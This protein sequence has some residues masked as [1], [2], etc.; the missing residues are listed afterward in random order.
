MKEIKGNKK[1]EQNEILHVLHVFGKLNRGGAESRVMD[2]YRNVDRAKV[3]FDFM[4]HTTKVCDFQPEIE[5]LGGKVYHV[6]PFRFWNY[7]S[8]CKAWKQ[9]IREHP[10]IR[11]VHGHMTSTASIYLP[12]VHKKGV[13][14]I[15]HSRNA[16]VDKGIKGKLTKF[17]RRNLTEKCDRCF[18]CSKLAG[19]AVFGKEAMEQGNVTIIPNAID[20]ARF[21]FDPE[22]RKQKREEL[23]IQPEEFLIG[24]VG[25]FDPQ[26]N[27]KYAVEILAECRKKNFPAKLIL[28]GE[29]PLMETVRQ[30]VEELQLQEYVIFTGLQKNVVPFYQAMDFFLLPSFYEGLPGVAVEAQASG[31][32]GILSDAITTETAMTSLMEFRNV[33][34]P[35]EVWADRIM[36]CGHYERQNTLKEMQEAGFDVKNLAKRLQDFYLR[37][38]EDPAQ[39]FI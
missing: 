17:L 38:S 23:H 24:E 11:I 9:F 12:I 27:Q 21:T 7:F 33:Q 22:V 6:P 16:G 4:Q 3:Q 1:T 25:R 36:A 8:Y 30:Q 2:L 19:E 35:A 31:L 32:R 15:A 5:Q 10:E 26:K 20:A 14:T 13:F 34:E 18:A 28:I 39:E 29:G 37:V